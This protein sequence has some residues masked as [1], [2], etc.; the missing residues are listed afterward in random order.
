MVQKYLPPLFIALIILT[1]VPASAQTV[2]LMETPTPVAT[3]QF[4]DTF[5]AEKMSAYHVP[6]AALVIV[7]DGEVIFSKGY[8][9]ANIENAIPVD[10]GKTVFRVASVSKIFTIAG[11]MQLGEAGLVDIGHDVNK[12]LNGFQVENDYEEPVRIKYLLTHTDGFET[13]DLGTFIQAPSDLPSLENVLKSDLNSPVQ[14]PGSTITYGG[15]GTALAG[16]LI[17]QVKN[18]SF[19]EYIEKNIFQ[20]LKMDSSTFNQV[21]PDNFKENIA[22]VYNYDEGSNNFIPAPFLYVATAPTGALSTTPEDMGNF[23][24][25]LLNG[26]TDGKNRILRQETVEQMFNRQYSPH[27]SLPGVTYGFM[28]YSYN[29]QRAL[30]RDGSGVGIRSQMFLLPEQNLGYFYVQNTRG[31]EIAEELSDAFMDRFFPTPVNTVTP[32]SAVYNKHLAEYEG[33]FRPAQTARHTLVKMEVLAMGDLRI[34]ARP[35][36]ELAV[37]VLGEQDVYGNFPKESTWFEVEPLLFRRVDKER[38]MAFQRNEKGE[39]AG[40]ASASGY[41]GAFVK[42]PWYE[43]SLTQMYWLIICIAMFFA[44]IIINTIKIVRGER[45]ILQTSGAISLLFVV[46]LLGAVYALFLHRIAGFP[47]FAFGV[48]STARVMLTLLVVA[49]VL[50]FGFLILLIGK[51][52]SG[53]IGTLDKIFYFVIMLIFSGAVYWL[54]YWNLLGYRY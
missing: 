52:V 47:A 2:P 25:A 50:S 1:K 7:K 37:T 39:I 26:G 40:L 10:P 21:L 12:Y 17:S 20:P 11:V 24:I 6:G 51:W 33:F 14:V 22:T 31:D 23:I 18:E 41:H 48:S 19:E 49:S 53:K 27:P 9:Y 54:N 34:A 32:N 38:Y 29:G 44:V 36:G 35:N 8:G 30:V 3:R 15:Y 28:E 42:I 46:G 5:F 16:Y 13:R 43:S 4:F 45:N